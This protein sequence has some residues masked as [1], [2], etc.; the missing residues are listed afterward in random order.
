LP[1]REHTLVAGNPRANLLHAEL[2]CFCRRNFPLNVLPQCWQIRPT[3]AKIS[4]H[5]REHVFVR[6]PRPP[7][8]N[9]LPHSAHGSVAG[10]AKPPIFRRCLASVAAT[11]EGLQIARG[12]SATSGFRY[13]VVAMGPISAVRGVVSTEFATIRLLAYIT[14]KHEC[15]ASEDLPSLTTIPTLGR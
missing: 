8:V 14:I 1:H 12:I 2:Q 5:L 6:G 3:L 9:A 4:K 11:T 15:L 7:W 10:I 13:D